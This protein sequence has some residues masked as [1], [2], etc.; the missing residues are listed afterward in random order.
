VTNICVY[1]YIFTKYYADANCIIIRPKDNAICIET[2][3]LKVM[4]FSSKYLT[5]R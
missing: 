3:G 1:I 5:S 4:K 2:C